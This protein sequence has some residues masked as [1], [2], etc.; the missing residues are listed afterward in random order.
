[1]IVIR[2][3]DGIFHTLVDHCTHNEKELYYLQD[4]EM[5]RCHSGKS[6]FD[7]QGNVM[8]GPAR[9]SLGVFP[10]WQEDDQLIIAMKSGVD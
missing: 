3:G 4:E 10:T 6:Y 2:S 5:L 1:M 7:I 8:K 9:K